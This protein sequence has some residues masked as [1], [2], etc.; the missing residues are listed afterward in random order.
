[1][2]EKQIQE[3]FNYLSNTMREQCI[4]IEKLSGRV[5][6]ITERIQASEKKLTDNDQIINGVFELSKNVAIYAKEVE[7]LA[8]TM[9]KRVKDI[10]ERQ[11]KQGE[12]IGALETKPAKRMEMII[13]TIITGFITLGIGL[14]VGRFVGG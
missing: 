3:R 12:R 13:T 4:L 8:K 14:L 9:D 7:H 2:D 6:V 11:C 5:D 1:M 10:E